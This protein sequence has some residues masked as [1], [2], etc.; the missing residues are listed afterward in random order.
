MIFNVIPLKVKSSPV[1]NPGKPNT[2]NTFKE[3]CFT[4]SKR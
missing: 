1:E 3:L 4:I 2:D